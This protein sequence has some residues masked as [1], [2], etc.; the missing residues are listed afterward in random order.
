[1]GFTVAQG[2]DLGVMLTHGGGY[3]GYGSYL[4]LLPDQGIGIFAFAN[5]T[6][7]A[8]VAPV[9]Q[10][11][12]EL[13]RAGLLPAR[14]LPVSDALARTYQAAAA[15]YHAGNLEPGRA[16]LAMNFLMDRNAENWAEEFRR[17]KD[18]TGTCRTDA[19]ITATGTLAGR[20]TWTC[21]RATLQGQVLLAPTNPP[22]IQSL[23]L[24]PV[25]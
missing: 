24:S 21:E 16:M 17:L 1:M 13:Q 22:T 11:A 6:Y 23:R 8:P 19:P 25:P 15:M 2:C 7:G 18:I 9:Y 3:P 10:A 5:R 14:T 12:F 4:L 20:F